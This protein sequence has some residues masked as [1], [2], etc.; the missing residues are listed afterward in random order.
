MDPAD[1]EDFNLVLVSE[2]GSRN[3]IAEF[4]AF[5]KNLNKLSKDLEATFLKYAGI[6]FYAENTGSNVP[7]F[8]CQGDE[9]QYMI[10]CA[11]MVGV[12]GGGL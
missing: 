2:Q 1:L 9:C 10:R 12:V 11:P 4:N 3:A 6:P 8:E 7:W 5:V